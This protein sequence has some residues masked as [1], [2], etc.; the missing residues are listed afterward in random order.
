MDHLARMI[1]HKLMA[2]LFRYTTITIDLSSVKIRLT[3]LD[4]ARRRQGTTS[5][6]WQMLLIYPLI[7]LDFHTYNMYMQ[8]LP[9]KP[10][11]TVRRHI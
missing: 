6:R 8:G 11:T 7:R 10:L 2:K 3:I 1:P 5:T 4:A 9:N